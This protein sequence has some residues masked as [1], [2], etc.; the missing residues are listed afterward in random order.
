MPKVFLSSYAKSISFL[1]E[2]P[3]NYLSD[4]LMGVKAD[5]EVPSRVAKKTSATLVCQRVFRYT[6]G[7][8]WSISQK[9]RISHRIQVESVF[10]QDSI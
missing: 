1:S 4:G 2:D 7:T 9:S 8:L 3:H 6:H 10:L 5:L